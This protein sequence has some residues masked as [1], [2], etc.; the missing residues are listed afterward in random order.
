METCSRELQYG[1]HGEGMVNKRQIKS[2]KV[3]SC[4]QVLSNQAELMGFELRLG[5]VGSHTA[6]NRKPGTLTLCSS[7]TPCKHSLRTWR[8][9][10]SDDLNSLLK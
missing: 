4:A 7:V 3:Q 5:I 2:M 10:R 6:Y 8:V 1:C 9:Q